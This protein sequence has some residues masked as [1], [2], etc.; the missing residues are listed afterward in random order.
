M[1][2]VVFNYYELD[3]QWQVEKY[4]SSCIIVGSFEFEFY[5]N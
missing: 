5:K 1:C 3:E 2:E 4:I